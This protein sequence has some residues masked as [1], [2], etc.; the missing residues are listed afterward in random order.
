MPPARGG[1]KR[2]KGLGLIVVDYLQLLTGSAKRSQE[3]RVQ[4]VSEITVGL[5]ALA[6]ELCVPVLALSQLSRQVENRDDK[7]P[8]LSDLRESGSIEQDA[9]V[10]MFVFREEYY[11]SRKE[12]SLS[13]VEE[14]Q[15]WQ[16]EMDQVQGLAEVV[17]GKQRHGPTG[18]VRLQ[19]QADITRFGDLANDRPPARAVR[20]EMTETFAQHI[21][22]QL[23]N[24]P[25]HATA[26]LVVRLGAI[27]RNY[28]EL[29][30]L[31]K[32]AETAA[33]VKANAYGLGVEQCA[34]ALA[35]EGCRTFFVATPAEAEALRAL[36]A[37]ATIY[38]LNGLLSGS[39]AFYNELRVR[40]V[41]GSLEEVTEWAAYCRSRGRK[42]PAAIHLDTGMARL[43]LKAHEA[44]QLAQDRGAFASFEP[45]LVMT[46]LVCGDDVESAMNDRQRT[47]FAELSALFP[48]VPRSLANS[49]GILLGPQFHFDVT[50]PGISLY[51]GNAQFNAENSIE[52][53]VWLFG[54]IAQVHWAEAG[55][56]VG[57]GAMHTLKRRTRIAT[58]CIGYADGYFTCI[59]RQRCARR[60]ARVYR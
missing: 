55:Q 50:R 53:V 21:A 9:D 34:P 45:S 29:R 59:L 17:I 10:V 60:I 16:D 40:P 25:A 22:R 41:L 19:F 51:G 43:G 20:L 26:A 39:A 54:R 44:L 12:P 7:R 13:K 23:A 38:V 32:G 28:G 30:T 52:P 5:K 33:V 6:K 15:K 35:K 36:S 57:Y 11:V 3:G 14:H 2:Q 8:Q 27:R 49:A 18:T 56:T 24:V 4:E 58:V 42:L 46:H 37:D 47:Q 31:A 1:L 48:G